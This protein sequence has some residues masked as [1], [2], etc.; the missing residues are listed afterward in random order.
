MKS[1]ATKDQDQAAMLAAI[2]PQLTE[3]SVAA[4]EAGFVLD[5]IHTVCDEQTSGA[6]ESLCYLILWAAK[7]GD[8]QAEHATKLVS[9]VQLQIEAVQKVA[10]R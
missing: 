7:Y 9:T 1:R 4:M 2:L 5:A 3:A 8:L 6:S 10:E